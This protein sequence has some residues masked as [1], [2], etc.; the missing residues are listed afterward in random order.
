MIERFDAELLR[1]EHSVRQGTSRVQ[2]ANPG[3]GGSSGLPGIGVLALLATVLAWRRLAVAPI[4][5]SAGR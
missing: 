2:I 1:F 3:G 5:G 4:P